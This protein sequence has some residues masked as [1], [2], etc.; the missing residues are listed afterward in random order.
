M[1]R[2]PNYFLKEAYKE[3]PQGACVRPVFVDYLPLET[4]KALGVILDTNPP[5]PYSY[6]NPAPT[7][8]PETDEVCYTR[9]GFL[10]IPKRLLV[11]R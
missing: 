5:K 11:E 8:Y 10:T 9:I 4:K 6:Y 1:S 2:T 3:L 7:F